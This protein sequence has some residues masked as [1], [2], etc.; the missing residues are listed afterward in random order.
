MSYPLTE[1]V[2][3]ITCYHHQSNVENSN[4]YQKLNKGLTL[5]CFQSKLVIH[6]FYCLLNLNQLF[7]SF[8]PFI[9]AHVYHISYQGRHSSVT[10]S[11][12]ITQ[13]ALLSSAI[14]GYVQRVTASARHPMR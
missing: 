11:I 3:V 12:T 1:F 5:Q 6:L 8:K 10:Y 7:K 13:L 4:C 14:H 9:E 2:N